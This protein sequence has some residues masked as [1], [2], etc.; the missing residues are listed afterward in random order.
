MAQQL[1]RAC[2]IHHSGTELRSSGC[3]LRPRRRRLEKSK[4]QNEK[5]REGKGK[6]RGE[7]APLGCN[8]HCTYSPLSSWYHLFWFARAGDCLGLTA[9]FARRLEGRDSFAARSP[10]SAIGR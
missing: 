2:A 5:P 6:H 8:P 1:S 9:L 10:L 4:I 3:R 7:R